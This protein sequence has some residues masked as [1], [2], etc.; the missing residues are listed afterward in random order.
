MPERLAPTLGYL[1]WTS[2]GNMGDEAINQAIAGRLPDDTR[3]VPV[4]L[5]PLALVGARG[6]LGELRQSPLV[7]GGGTVVGR[8]IW[9]FHLLQGL[10]LTA[11]SPARMI[12]AG[13]EDPAFA[14]QGHLS[15]RRELRRWRRLLDRFARVT[16]RGPRS[17]EL[18][19]EVGVAA[20]VVGDPAL[21]LEP[22]WPENERPEPTDHIGIALGAADDLWGH[23]Q[24]AVVDTTA[25]V[26]A[27]LGSRW[28]FRFLVVNRG[29]R[30]DAERCAAVSGL[31]PSRWE[32]V[33]AAEPDG[34]QRAVAGCRLVVAER[35]HAGILAAR[36]G[37]PPVMLEYQ[38]KCRDFLR[39][40]G[41]EH[42]GRRTDR[43]DVTDLVTLLDDVAGSAGVIAQELESRVNDLRALLLKES[44]AL[45][46]AA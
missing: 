26:L 23:D 9:R 22:P 45:A 19:A 2:F 37:I 28:R 12:G 41:Q 7:L 35:L 44:A 24:A 39:S 38:P 29:D 14:R 42:L 46:L 31:P 30:P 1:G 33:E 13:V 4:P 43:L 27:Q 36:L 32:I 6:R 20:E 18:L 11:R 16:V 25:A 8:R 5:G 10:A 21:L 15:E 17:A 3:L 40:V 34:Y